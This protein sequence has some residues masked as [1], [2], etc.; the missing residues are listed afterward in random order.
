MNRPWEDEGT[1]EGTLLDWPRHWREQGRR[2]GGAELLLR[3]TE[4]KFGPLGSHDRMRI[5]LAPPDRLLDWG[6][7]VLTARTID[8]VFQW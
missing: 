6:E 4:R 1:T 8:E 2:Q 3:Q 7:R 5:E